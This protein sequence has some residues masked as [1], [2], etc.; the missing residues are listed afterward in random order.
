MGLGLFDGFA[1]P[2][3]GQGVFGPGI[4]DASSGA[5]GIAGYNHPLQHRVRISLQQAAVHECAR[6]SL[7]GVANQVFYISRFL[8]GS[9]PLEPGGKAGSPAP[10]QTGNLDFLDYLL[11]GHLV[12]GFL[13]GL[14]PTTIY[15]VLDR[16]RI[17]GAAVA[18][19]YPH[20][21]G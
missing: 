21:P 1:Q 16:F 7:I 17:D 15:I 11:G 5:D 2:L 9:V 19:G 14:V 20:L 3:D 12:K 18:Q 4:D 8:A 6:V 10:F 13:E